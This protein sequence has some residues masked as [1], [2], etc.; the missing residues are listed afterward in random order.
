M[1]GGLTHH[2]ARRLDTR[3]VSPV[4]GLRRSP[5]VLRAE[6]ALVRACGVDDEDFSDSHMRK[7]IVVAFS[8]A[9]DAKARNAELARWLDG[10]D[11]DDA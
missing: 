1:G 7:Q 10:G 2:R 8:L 5:R 4:L 9:K 6:N 3:A 11:G